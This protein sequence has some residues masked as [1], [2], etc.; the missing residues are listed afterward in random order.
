MR[1]ELVKEPVDSEVL[2]G[3][4]NSL[5]H[6][7]SPLASQVQVKAGSIKDAMMNNYHLLTFC[8]MFLGCNAMQDCSTSYPVGQAIQDQPSYKI[9][10]VFLNLPTGNHEVQKNAD[11]TPPA[12]VGRYTTRPF[13]FSEVV[14][15][16]DFFGVVL[17]LLYPTLL[18][19]GAN[20]H[21]FCVVLARH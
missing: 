15:N 20:S 9:S 6:L 7:K 18:C 8:G 14:L 11:S 1:P 21:L 2:P 13:C 4:L 17:A 3:F 19:S 10:D 12:H 16:E 5:S